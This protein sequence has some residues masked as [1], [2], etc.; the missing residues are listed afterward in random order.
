MLEET[1][2]C[3]YEPTITGVIF[4]PK[5]LTNSG[6]VD[7]INTGNPYQRSKRGKIVKLIRRKGAK[8]N[9]PQIKITF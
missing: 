3:N 4:I 9:E 8:E 1:V 7:F 2:G 6:F 5:W